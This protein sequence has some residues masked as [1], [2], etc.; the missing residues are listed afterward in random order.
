[1]FRM[2]MRKMI[3]IMLLSLT[4]FSTTGFAAGKQPDMEKGFYG[5]ITDE[6]GTLISNAE[7]SMFDGFTIRNTR[8]DSN[9]KYIIPGLP[10]SKN[11]YLVIFFTK[12]GLIPR[13]DNILVDDI[14]IIEHSPVMKRV[15][16]QDIGFIIGTVYKPIRGGKIRY[17]NGINSFVKKME[18]LLEGNS[19][20]ITKE[21]GPD[22]QF[23]FE[24]PAGKYTLGIGGSRE[25]VEID[26]SAGE[27]VIKNLRSGFTLVD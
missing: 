13:A 9:G 11:N 21:T 14:K 7:V 2:N 18:V 5:H 6:N 20:V 12:E 10:V 3:V 26:L 23:I 15:T 24:V 4:L 8:T 22:G 27:T 16:T 19:K 17:S 1:M 25:K